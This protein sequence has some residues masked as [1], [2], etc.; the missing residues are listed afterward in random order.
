MKRKM[1]IFLF[2]ICSL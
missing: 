1:L 2:M